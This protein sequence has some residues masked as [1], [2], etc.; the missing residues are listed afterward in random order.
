MLSAFFDI[1]HHRCAPKQNIYRERALA[2]QIWAK[3]RLT[4]LEYSRP[5]GQ[6]HA[7]IFNTD[8]ESTSS[9]NMSKLNIISIQDCVDQ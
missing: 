4:V 3:E 6:A 1:L 8:R 5:M 7:Y 9:E 2:Q